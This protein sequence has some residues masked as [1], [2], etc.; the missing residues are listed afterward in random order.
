MGERVGGVPRDAGGET[1]RGPGGSV[2]GG[3]RGGSS[4]KSDCRDQMRMRPRESAVTH[5]SGTFVEE[6]EERSEFQIGRRKTGDEKVCWTDL[7]R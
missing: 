6:G 5:R 1:E 4:R 7:R 2:E 3:S